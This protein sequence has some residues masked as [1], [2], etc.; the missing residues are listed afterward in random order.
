MFGIIVAAAFAF[1]IIFLIV[2]SAVVVPQQTTYIIERLGKYHQTYE[3]GFHLMIPIVDR[4]AYKFSLKEEVID[5]P[6]QTCITKDNVG[7]EVDGLVYIKVEDPQKAAYGITNYRQAAMQL[8]QT[9]LRSSVGQIDLDKTFE[10]RELLNAK[11]VDAVDQAAETWGIKVLR[12]EIKD[13]T[14]PPTVRD[15]M[16]AQM[17]AERQKRA[18]IAQSEGQKQEAINISEGQKQQTIN[19]ADAE[20]QRL[21]LEAEG[22]ALAIERVAMAQAQQIEAL[23]QATAQGIRYVALAYNEKGGDEAANLR[24]AEQMVA[25]FGNIAKQGTTLLLPQNMSDISGLVATAMTT[26]ESLK[27][28]KT[29][30][31]GGVVK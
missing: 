19:L 31:T 5:T 11:V 8:S 9:S 6:S 3:A 23:A 27:G 14:P 22:Q 25:A 12:F 18:L 1:V 15:A 4:V 7:V 16:E 30:K 10:E 2:A 13:I 29:A 17:T 26:L 24:V 21:I 20:Q 28:Q